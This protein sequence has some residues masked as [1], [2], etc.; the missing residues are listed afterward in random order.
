MV[1]FFAAP[2]RMIPHGTG[3]LCVAWHLQDVE[4]YAK[5]TQT[6]AVSV[7]EK[8]SDEEGEEEESEPSRDPLG[9]G[10]KGGH[11]DDTIEPEKHV[12]TLQCMQCVCVCVC[13]HVCACVEQ[14]NESY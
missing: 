14:V 1:L 12:S 9:T 6:D 5:E 4:V 3:G 8:A 11:H 10:F 2:Y 7:R 13:M